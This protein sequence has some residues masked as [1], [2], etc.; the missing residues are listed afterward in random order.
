MSPIRPVLWL[1]FAAALTA[2]GAANAQQPHPHD[3][4]AQPS[5]PPPT[6]AA[7]SH[8]EH[9]RSAEATQ[10]QEIGHSQ[11]HHSHDV[12]HSR[13]QHRPDD[14]DHA[15][16]DHGQHGDQAD[17]H[18]H[19]DH[20]HAAGQMKP[21]HD[22]RDPI[23]PVTDA[24]RAAAFPDLQQHHQHGSSRHSFWLLDQ[25]ETSDASGGTDISWEGSAWIGSDLNRLWLRT[26]GHAL[27]GD[28]EKGRFEVLYGR[29]IRPWWDL[30]AGIRQD[31]GDGPSRTWAA[32]GVQGM[33]PY[34]FELEA[35]GYVGEA[36]RTALNLE[37]K[38]EMLF[39]NRLILTW[40]A[41]ATA[42][43][44]SDPEQL[45]GSGL[46]TIET[47]LRLRYEFSRQFAP[48]IGF[49]REWSYGRT[50]DLRELAGHDSGDSKWVVGVRLWF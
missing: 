19:G 30:V 45:V 22:L 38:Y 35:T 37:A 39:T 18:A 13:M 20:P 1:T 29:P 6:E 11:M 41:E 40:G 8:G 28:V 44:K 17:G 14:I 43:G 21:D 3:H 9:P 36:G 12:D 32:F 5:P 23:P 4:S 27:D 48:Y 15:Q 16:M 24:D 47:G 33:A 25:L 26:K 50:S 34:F 46:S 42:F 10:G 2:A 31:F 49:E 7:D